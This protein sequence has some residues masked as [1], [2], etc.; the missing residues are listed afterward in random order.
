MHGPILWTLGD[1]VYTAVGGHGSLQLQN[2]GNWVDVVAIPK[3]GPL[4]LE[5]AFILP[6]VV[7]LPVMLWAAE[8]VTRFIDEPCV[9]FSYWLYYR[10]TPSRP[11]SL[12]YTQQ[13]H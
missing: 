3:A 12:G 8:M 10:I 4:G 5:V 1:L 7:L 13:S 2:L 11:D 6:H 9:K